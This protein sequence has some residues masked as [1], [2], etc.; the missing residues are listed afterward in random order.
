MDLK[1]Y[2]V[3]FNLVEQNGITAHLNTIPQLPEFYSI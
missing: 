3:S 2:F 1:C